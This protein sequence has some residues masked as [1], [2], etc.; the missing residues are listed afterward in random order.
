MI[1]RPPRS[2][3]TD[4]LFPVTTLVR[5]P[6]CRLISSWGWS[7]SQGYGCSPFKEVRE[8]GLERR[9]TVRSLSAVGVRDLRGAAPSTRGPGGSEEHTS[10]LQS[11][12]RISYAVFCLKHKPSYDYRRS[13]KLYHF[14]Q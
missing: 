3:R 11:L 4:T 12:L 8:L 14:P 2:R 13:Q 10:E 9:E 5:S 7:R 6:R 1:R